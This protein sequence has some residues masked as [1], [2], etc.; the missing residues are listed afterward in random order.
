MTTTGAEDNED[1]NEDNDDDLNIDTADGG[2]HFPTSHQGVTGGTLHHSNLRKSDNADTKEK[3]KQPLFTPRRSTKQ[4]KGR[5]RAAS[6]SSFSTTHTTETITTRPWWDQSPFT[7]S[8]ISIG[9]KSNASSCHQTPQP[10]SHMHVP[11]PQHAE[12]STSS[13]AA[14]D[15]HRLHPLYQPDTQTHPHPYQHQYH[16]E[17]PSF[18]YTI[19]EDDE[20]DDTEEDEAHDTDEAEQDDLSDIERQWAAENDES[21][22]H[23]ETDRIIMSPIPNP[24]NEPLISLRPLRDQPSA[25]VTS[26][27]VIATSNAGD[28]SK[29]GTLTAKQQLALAAN[30]P[31]KERRSKKAERKH[32]MKREKTIRDEDEPNRLKKMLGAKYR[33]KRRVQGHINADDISRDWTKTPRTLKQ[34]QMTSGALVAGHYGH[35]HERMGNISGGISGINGHHTVL[36]SSPLSSEID[37]PSTN[38]DQAARPAPTPIQPLN[39]TPPDSISDRQ[40]EGVSDGLVMPSFAISNGAR[41]DD[42]RRPTWVTA[43]TSFGESSRQAYPIYEDD[44]PISEEDEEQDDEQEE[45]LP[46]ENDAEAGQAASQDTNDAQ[47]PNH[48]DTTEGEPN[49]TALERAS[50]LLKSFSFKRSPTTSTSAKSQRRR[51]SSTGGAPG[52]ICTTEAEHQEALERH[53]NKKHVRFLTKVQ[54]S[55]LSRQPTA[56]AGVF[57]PPAKNPILKQDRMLVRKEVTERPGPHVFNAVT[58]RRLD[59]QSQ[60]WKEWWCVLKGPPAQS[61]EPKRRTKILKK[62]RKEKEKAVEK[63]RLEIYYNHKKIMGTILLTS[64]TTVSVYSS[65]DYTIALTQN[66]K[67]EIGLTVYILRPRTVALACSWYMEL[68]SLLHGE[69][70]IPSFIEINIPDFDVKVRVPIPEDSESE[71]EVDSDDCSTS[72]GLESSESGRGVGW[73]DANTTESTVSSRGH[74]NDANGPHG[75]GNNNHNANLSKIDSPDD[76]TSQSPSSSTNDEETT[77]E[78]GRKGTLHRAKGGTSAALNDIIPSRQTA[79]TQQESDLL[80]SFRTALERLPSRMAS[81]SFYMSSGV[82]AKPTLVTPQEVTP[83]LLRSHVL[84]LLK[85]VPDWAEV[86]KMWLDPAQHGDVALCWKRYDRIEWIYFTNPVPAETDNLHLKQS[87]IGYAFGTEWSGDMDTTVVGP[88]VLDKTHILEL[89]PVTHYPSKVKEKNGTELEEPDPIEGFLI[90][91]SSFTGKSLRR[92]RRLYLSSHDHLLMYTIPSQSHCPTMQHAGEMIDPSILM[93]CITPHRSANP[94]QKG[95]SQSRSVRR[96]KAQARSARGF[97]DLTKVKSAK[98]LTV[99]EW[100]LLRGVPI[101]E[102]AP[103]R[104]SETAAPISSHSR[105]HTVSGSNEVVES[106]GAISEAGEV[107]EGNNYFFPEVQ[108]AATDSHPTQQASSDYPRPTA[109]ILRRTTMAIDRFIHPDDALLMQQKED[110]Y[111]NVFAIEMENG[112]S[113]RFRAYNA[114]AAKL[115]CE[116]IEK[117]AH[118]WRVRKHMDVKLRMHVAHANAQL[119][120]TLDDDEVQVGETI[121]EWDNDRAMADPLIWNWCIPNGCRS[122][123]K[124]GMVY[125][126]PKLHRT[127]RKVFLVLTEGCLLL[128]HPHRRSH[129][130]GQLVPTTNCK[131]LGIH[132]LTDV[133][134]YSG[135]FSDEDTSHGTNDESERLPRYFPDGLIVD[136]PDEDCTFSIWRPK[137]RMFFSRKRTQAREAQ[138]MRGSSSTLAAGTASTGWLGGRIKEG[139]VYGSKAKSCEVFRAR[140]RADLEEWVYAI[141]IEIEKCV[142]QERKV[143]RAAAGLRT[144][145][146]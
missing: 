58:A 52:S 133:Y 83:A 102:A 145:V 22:A 60:G 124:S 134:I 89:R 72:D 68:Y 86:V 11:Q 14:V 80:D 84:H 105:S 81:R 114:E 25:A 123:T 37:L 57:L 104:G 45:R 95:I 64:N 122:I 142:R 31:V 91:V 93:F 16:H 10:P 107:G 97:I 38:T 13:P 117:L 7:R 59:R 50:T 6:V 101:T 46:G 27:D 126:K 82:D 98:V 146:V 51:N 26:T 96:L 8:R 49:L 34:R 55:S 24:K 18:A 137:R 43:V 33:D 40:Q 132:S 62:R 71:T 118:Y 21:D 125:Y 120:S 100:H 129:T 116:Q 30:P 78:E 28:M 12:G 1:S 136:D 90:R 19:S 15:N 112:V 76:S 4:K 17:Q 143:F 94:D 110:E 121:Q 111:S 106:S 139:V 130:S 32:V 9:A 87:H 75:R 42:G 85:D 141:Q 99:R 144:K 66:Y 135:H 69:P 140:S 103:E 65:L 61:T 41:E 20:P 109:T 2:T 56:V 128:F 127:F 113:V 39:T 115:W 54:I 131:L 92:Y 74:L 108:T 36:V 67:D 44:E 73:S 3:K 77:G 138:G 23:D 88:Q 48:E 47:P 70:P 79:L 63:G 29:Q 119:A 35:Q 5:G 53:V